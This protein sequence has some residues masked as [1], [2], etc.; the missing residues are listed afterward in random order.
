M[1]DPRPVFAGIG[2]K[3]WA[4][5]CFALAFII[6]LA[7]MAFNAWGEGEQVTD[8][9]PPACPPNTLYVRISVGDAGRIIYAGCL[10][11]VELRRGPIQAHVADRQAMVCRALIVRGRCGFDFTEEAGPPW[12]R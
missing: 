12:S 11:A 2:L 4:R 8:S 9:P 3:A 7:M 6:W 10:P 5:L 1:I